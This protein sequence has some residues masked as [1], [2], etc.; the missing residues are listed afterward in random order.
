[1]TDMILQTRMKRCQKLL[2][3]LELLFSDTQH[4]HGASLVY[5]RLGQKLMPRPQK[6]RL[7]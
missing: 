5:G 6:E 3:G 2:G 4:V 1:V 7:H